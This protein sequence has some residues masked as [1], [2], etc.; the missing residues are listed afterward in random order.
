VCSPCYLVVWGGSLVGAAVAK[1]AGGLA[2]GRGGGVMWPS[3]GLK[4]HACVHGLLVL[5]Q[6]LPKL[7]QL[8]MRME[9][10]GSA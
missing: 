4:T 5:F 9:L 7:G 3:R 1:K 2:F 6:L 10:G 8:G